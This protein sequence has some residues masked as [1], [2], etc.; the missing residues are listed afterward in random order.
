MQVACRIHLLDSIRTYTNIP[1]KE[2]TPEHVLQVNNILFV[3]INRDTCKLFLE[4]T[5]YKEHMFNVVS[6]HKL[7][8]SILKLLLI[9]AVLRSGKFRPSGYVGQY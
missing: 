7:T 9:C 5:E 1:L 6:G 2:R 8:T 3:L 4:R